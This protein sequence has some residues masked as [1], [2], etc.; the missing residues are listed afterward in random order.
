MQQIAQK[1]D[2]D[3]LDWVEK[4][5]H[6]VGWLVGWLVGFKTY[7]HFSGHLTLD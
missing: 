2:N 6:R 5:S 3:R 1:N 4:N 7:Q